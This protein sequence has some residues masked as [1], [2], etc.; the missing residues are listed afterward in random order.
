MRELGSRPTSSGTSSVSKSLELMD[1]TSS[2][3]VL[4]AEVSASNGI[5]SGVS[6]GREMSNF[7]GI[8]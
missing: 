5:T 6:A 2:S 4:V 3:T 8:V 1:L 7:L